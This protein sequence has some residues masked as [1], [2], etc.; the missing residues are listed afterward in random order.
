MFY[1][2]GGFRRATR[3]VIHRMQRLPDRPHRI[4]RGV[5][6]GSLIGFLPLPGLQ[7]L[8]AWGLA[9]LMRGNI[10][11]ALLATFN[12]NP[13]TTPFFAVGAISLGHWMLGI[14]TPLT[15]EAIG[16]G[17]GRAGTELWHNFLAIFGPEHMHWDGLAQFWSDIYLPYFI[18]ALGPGILLSL[19]F[20]YITIPLVEAYQNAR[21]V[22]FKEQSEK[23][24]LLR[25]KLAALGL[26][27]EP[28]K[29]PVR[30]PVTDTKQGDD[31][32]PPAP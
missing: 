32:P 27:G 22:K 2:T 8:G 19:I 6:A 4:A 5:F 9:F 18:G 26:R 11:A 20:Y 7:F 28:K 24:L 31:V 10:L 17:F 1:P 29:G 21:S 25:E 12:S 30:D 3:Y 23:R 15:A 13:I 14:D 16:D